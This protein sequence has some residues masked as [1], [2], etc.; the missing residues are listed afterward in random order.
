MNSLGKN[1]SIIFLHHSTGGVI[2][3]GGVPEWFSDYNTR[4]G[5]DYRIIERA[6][7][8][9]EPYGWKNYPYDYWNIWVEHAGEKP[10]MDEPTL[11]MLAREHQVIVWKH[12]YPVSNVEEDTGT[13]DIRSEHKRIENYKL[14]YAVLKEK[15]RSFPGVRFVV[16]TGAALV[17]E[18][19]REENAK[20]A[21]EF[22]EWVRNEWDE[23]GDN[24][25]LWDLYEL[26]TDGG[27]YLKDEYAAKTGDSH[28]GEAFAKKAAPLFCRRLAAVIEGRG[29][30]TSLTGE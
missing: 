30:K 4:N 2:W 27:M 16:W 9:R 15:M 10:F 14:Q 18:A 25:F 3:R 8:Q 28:P 22:F 6:F 17:K 5:T 20:R 21:R 7:P 11:E 23:P 1:V 29:D 24:I 19:I 12:C 26:E 13:P